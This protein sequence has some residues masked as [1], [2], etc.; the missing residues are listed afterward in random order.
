MVSTWGKP[1]KFFLNLKKQKAI[2]TTVRHLNVDIKV[3]TDLKEIKA[4]ICKF[5]KKKLKKNVSKADSER[6]SLLNSIVLPNLNFKGVDIC[7]SEITE[8]D[9]ITAH[10]SMPNCKFSGPEDLTKELYEHFWKDFKTYFINSL[11]Q[12][13]IDDHLPISQRQAIIKLI[14]ENDR[15][16]IFV[17]N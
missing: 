6:D 3:I 17:K 4:Y 13:K 15:D 1:A 11:R 2:N 7:E 16:K 9:L 12:S 10:K 8:K 5:S 14:V